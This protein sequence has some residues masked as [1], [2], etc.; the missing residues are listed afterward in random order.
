MNVHSAAHASTFVPKGAETR[1]DASFVASEPPRRNAGGTPAHAPRVRYDRGPSGKDYVS[2]LMTTVEHVDDLT[3]LELSQ[4]AQGL[5]VDE[6]NPS[7]PSAEQ[8]KGALTHAFKVAELCVRFCDPRVGDALLDGRQYVRA[9]KRDLIKGGASETDA[10]AYMK[11]CARLGKMDLLH[12]DAS[13]NKTRIDFFLG[14][15]HVLKQGVLSAKFAEEAERFR[16][17]ARAAGDL[18]FDRQTLNNR[19]GWQAEKLPAF[20]ALTER[21]FPSEQK[22]EARV[23]FSKGGV[24]AQMHSV[25]GDGKKPILIDGLAT[26][27]EQRRWA[28]DQA[29]DKRADWVPGLLITRNNMDK[30]KKSVVEKFPE[31]EKRTNERLCRLEIPAWPD[32]EPT[33]MGYHG[34]QSDPGKM[35]DV[36]R[37]LASFV[38]DR[39]KT[40]QA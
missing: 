21:V 15:R 36:G 9:T 31:S 5:E 17:P 12:T 29:G 18:V 24:N 13:G 20:I 7:K 22:V 19:I 23:G 26:S 30:P 25:I 34:A 4:L 38:T 39:N 14:T 35:R 16:G 8:I 27:L 6:K 33:L 37:S 2:N 3:D 32:E 11:E 40:I 10:D 28:L 1:P